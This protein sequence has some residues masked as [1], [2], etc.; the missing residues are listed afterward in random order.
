MRGSGV[1]PVEEGTKVDV[2]S[3]NEDD[4]TRSE[5]L[6]PLLRPSSALLDLPGEV[7]VSEVP[8]STSGSGGKGAVS[9]SPPIDHPPK[10]LPESSTKKEDFSITTATFATSSIATEEK[11]FFTNFH[12]AAQQLSLLGIKA[13]GLATQIQAI[14]GHMMM[15]QLI[16]DHIATLTEDEA[17]YSALLKEAHKELR[18]VVD[19]PGSGDVG[20]GGSRDDHGET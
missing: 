10:P 12:I 5:S 9:V 19:R 17:K 7:S 13:V 15:L 20:H 6:K 8:H 11:I 18:I 2:V 4:G 3:S 1:E 16:D 14:R